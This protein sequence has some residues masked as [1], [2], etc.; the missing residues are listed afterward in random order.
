MPAQMGAIG[1]YIH[2]YFIL[3]IFIYR[4]F[5]IYHTCFLVLFFLMLC[6]K[7]IKHLDLAGQF[8]TAQSHAA[9]AR[10]SQ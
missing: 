6:A 8:L 9:T 1:M 2:L 5:V 10:V 3:Y 4:L 7:V